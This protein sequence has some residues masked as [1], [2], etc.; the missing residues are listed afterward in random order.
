M[1]SDLMQ[2]T[3]LSSDTACLS[4]PLWPCV[5]LSALKLSVWL[6]ICSLRQFL[7]HSWC[8]ISSANLSDVIQVQCARAES[9]GVSIRFI[10]P[11]RCHQTLTRL[12]FM[13]MHAQ[14]H[15][16]R[17]AIWADV[18]YRYGMAEGCYAGGPI[19]RFDLRRCCGPAAR[20]FK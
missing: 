17:C 10:C 8:V 19:L 20:C 15:A 12:D 9:P 7:F 5:C 13:R 18:K 3:H 11:L 16:K 2:V 14:V 4:V 6:S 1:G